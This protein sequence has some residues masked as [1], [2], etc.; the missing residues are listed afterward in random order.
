MNKSTDVLRVLI[1]DDDNVDRLSIKRALRGVRDYLFDIDEVNS[2]QTAEIT[3]GRDHYDI[4]F[5]D[6]L[7]PDGDGLSVLVKARSNNI[8]TPVIVLTGQGDERLAVDLMQSGAAD[9]LPKSTITAQIL[10]DSVRNALQQYHRE[11]ER[12][13][14][15]QELQ[16]KNHRIEDILES[17]SDAF[18]ALDAQW[19]FTFVNPQAET[20]LNINASDVASKNVFEV[21][22][23]MDSWFREALEQ[24][25]HDGGRRSCEG[26][27]SAVEKW[28]EVHVYP[29]Q[30]GVSVYFQDISMRKAQEVELSHL[31]KYDSLT[32]LPNR[33]TLQEEIQR[34]IAENGQA[35]TKMAVLYC[36]LDG[37]KEIN[38]T[39]GHDAGDKLL[40]IIGKRLGSAVRMQ[41]TVARLG[42]DEFVV[43]LR[44]IARLEDASRVAANLIHMISKPIQ[45]GTEHTSV[46]ASVGVSIF[47]EH[48][49]DAETLLKHA[50]S[51]M[52]F[53]K[54]TGKNRLEFY[55]ETLEENLKRKM[56]LKRE[57]QNALREDQ[58]ELYYQP[59][60][61]I[62]ERH[63]TGIE[64]LLRWRHPE[65]G[66]LTPDRFLQIAQETDLI[67]PIENWVLDK[68]I[69]DMAAWQQAG[70]KNLGVAI[71]ISQS[72]FKS[73]GFVEAISA[74]LN[75]YQMAPANLSVELT[76]DSVIAQ[77]KNIIDI[78]HALKKIGVNI[79]IDNFG[80]GYASVALLGNMPIDAVKIDKSFVRN[81]KES[82]KDAAMTK[83]IYT[84]GSSLGIKVVVGGIENVEQQEVVESFACH[85]VQGYLYCHPMPAKELWEFLAEF[86][87]VFGGRRQGAVHTP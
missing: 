22:V 39:L 17:I 33:L 63:I 27:Y 86:N 71:N 70:H 42:G 81:I 58:L 61:D 5:L 38:D 84:M 23:G 57:L 50:D 52:Y 62:Q 85:N 59:Q 12:K 54:Q 74:T 51:A 21:L 47:P 10:E 3:L 41:D 40:Q 45:L 2:A 46:T 19:R 9:Y 77:S 36:D 26:Y 30:E 65:Q 34:G 8:D 60:I 11:L 6:Y 48:G 66:I 73:K 37:F 18:F 49:R 43:L 4:I 28:L 78:L 83:A 32:D 55:S 25:A 68:A 1:I 14:A 7:L 15:H 16:N 69:S 75:K 44:D 13:L 87:D 20:L 79:C 76:E 72:Q 56:A 67:I 24:G 29:G 64:A 31:A 53:A 35:D 80:K 82:K